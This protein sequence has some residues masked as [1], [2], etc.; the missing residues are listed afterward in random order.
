MH[1]WRSPFARKIPFIGLDAGEYHNMD[2]VDSK[3]HLCDGLSCLFVKDT[4]KI[5]VIKWRVPAATEIPKL[6]G[7]HLCQ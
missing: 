5:A 4:A 6:K 1:T 3:F 7:A 2:N